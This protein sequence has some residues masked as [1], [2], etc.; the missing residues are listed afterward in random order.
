MEEKIAA[1]HQLY[2]FWHE[3]TWLLHNIFDKILGVSLCLGV[4]E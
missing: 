3:G 1:R 2:N 4:C